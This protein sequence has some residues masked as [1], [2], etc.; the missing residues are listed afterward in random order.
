MAGTGGWTFWQLHVRDSQL[1][2]L[3]LGTPVLTSWE[4]LAMNPVSL[5][6]QSR[7][8]REPP[9]EVRDPSGRVLPPA[10]ALIL[11]ATRNCYKGGKGGG[12]RERCLCH[13]QRERRSRLQGELG[14]Q[15]NTLFGNNSAETQPPLP[16][17]SLLFTTQCSALRNGGCSEVT[18]RPLGL[19]QGAAQAS[20]PSWSGR[21]WSRAA[22]L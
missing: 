4:L 21:A 11:S 3:G 2:S 6:N 9:D 20:C 15:S 22:H 8:F 17:L 1:A 5:G 7:L 16:S 18:G 10:P 12:R 13:R 19:N 14:G